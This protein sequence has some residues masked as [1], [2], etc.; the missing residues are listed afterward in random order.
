MKKLIIGAL[1]ALASI[2]HAAT[3]VPSTLINWISVP[4][5]PSV[6]AGTVFAGPAAA[7]GAPTFRTLATSDLPVVPVSKGGTGC[8]VA[9]GACLDSITG[10]SGIGF[11][12]RSG[13]GSYAFVA[14]PL[15]IANGGTGATTVAAARAA[16]GAAASGAN[17]DITSLNAPALGAATAT[18]ATAGDNSTKVATTAYVQTSIASIGPYNSATGTGVSV[19]SGTPANCTSASLAAGEYD[20]QGVVAWQ[21]G[22]AV[23]QTSGGVGIS[24]TSATF[25]A[26]GSYVS[27]SRASSTTADTYASPVVR[28]SLGSPTTIYQVIVATYSSGALT[29]N[30]LMRWRRIP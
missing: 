20:V 5:W 27:H 19:T 3:M 2:A 15:P 18:T 12:K 16:L 1:F 29:A 4:T 26:V 13:A 11:V 17:T 28:I 30:C 22:G 8:S 21:T 14:D 9:T 10:F 25:G 23:S 24:T 6:S 7:S